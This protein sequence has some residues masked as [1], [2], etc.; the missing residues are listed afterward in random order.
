MAPRPQYQPELAEKTKN[1]PQSLTFRSFREPE[2]CYISN[3]PVYFQEM[4]LSKLV[5]TQEGIPTFQSGSPTT[6]SGLNWPKDVK[7][8]PHIYQVPL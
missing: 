1:H 2:S 8:H 5:M 6:K 3:K 7:N 4:T